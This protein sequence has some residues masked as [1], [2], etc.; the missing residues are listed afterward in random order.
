MDFKFYAPK[1][2]MHHKKLI[3]YLFFV[4]LHYI[5]ILFEGSEYTWIR[6]MKL[7]L[8]IKHI[9]HLWILND[10]SVAWTSLFPQI[11]LRRKRK[12]FIVVIYYRH[13]VKQGLNDKFIKLLKM[14]L[15]LRCKKNYKRWFFEA[16]EQNKT[17]VFKISKE[18]WAEGVYVSCF[19][20]RATLHGRAAT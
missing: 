13:V 14:L 10:S 20:H 7:Y 12:D 8:N 2:F 6:N 9:Y 1:N 3:F 11:S 19:S 4:T 15:W 5:P 18:Q 16:Q 17:C